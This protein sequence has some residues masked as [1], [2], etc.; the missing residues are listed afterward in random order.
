MRRCR[1]PEL[2]PLPVRKAHNSMNTDISCDPAFKPAALD[3]IDVVY[4]VTA[5]FV[6][7]AGAYNGVPTKETLVSLINS[8]AGFTSDNVESIAILEVKMDEE[9]IAKS[10]GLSERS[11]ERRVGKECVSKCRSRWSP[12]TKQNNNQKKLK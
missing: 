12:Y 9:L 4:E 1:Q 6:V 5:K 3:A 2:T 8:G 7:T 10:E 11:E